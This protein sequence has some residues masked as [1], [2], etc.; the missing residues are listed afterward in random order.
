M[1]DE[2]QQPPAPTQDD[3]DSGFS[4]SLSKSVATNDTS[5]KREVSKLSIYSV[6]IV[7]ANKELNSREIEVT[8]VEHMPMINGEV[9][10]NISSIETKGTKQDGSSYESS[11]PA[12]NSIRAEWL[13]LGSAN[14]LTPPDV[15]RGEYVAVYKYGDHDKYYW[16]TLKDDI[17]LRKRE[18]VVYCYS[19]TSEEATNAGPESTYFIEIST[20]KKLITLH[21]SENDGELTTYDI[22][23]NTKDGYFVLVDGLGN[24]FRINSKE[25]SFLMQNTSG[26]FV[27]L[28]KDDLTIN[29]NGKMLVSAAG[30]YTLQAPTIDETGERT[31]NGN[32][33][34]VGTTTTGGLNIGGNGG[35]GSATISGSINASGPIN[36]ASS[37]NAPNIR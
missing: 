17:N 3:K 13:P 9:N 2:V 16:V 20:H 34:T 18:T 12:T 6:G 36:S 15:R 31:L 24:V 33:T 28:E 4:Q 30:G 14:R 5:E 8:P 32:E 22:Q 7:A 37:V 19:N 25:E 23:L 10:D 11:A 26:N 21:T 29:L 27:L 35:S 1:A